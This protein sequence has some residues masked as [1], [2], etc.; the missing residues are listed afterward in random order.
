MRGRRKIYPV[1][2]EYVWEPAGA[3]AGREEL[4]ASHYREKENVQMYAQRKRYRFC[5]FSG[6]THDSSVSISRC[7][8]ANTPMASVNRSGREMP[9]MG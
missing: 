2:F 5:T 1:C 4:T 6:A 7:P 9:R 8:K 3:A